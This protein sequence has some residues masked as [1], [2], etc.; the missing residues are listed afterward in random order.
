MKSILLFLSV[1]SGIILSAQN[2]QMGVP[3]TDENAISTNPTTLVMPFNDFVLM[4]YEHQN[5]MD[6]NSEIWYRDISNFGN[7]M[8][9]FA[10]NGIDFLN[11][12]LLKLSQGAND[13]LLFLF[14]TTHI[15][16]NYKV[17]Y[18][19]FD[20]NLNFFQPQMLIS[21][22]NNPRF[23]LD[24]YG[25]FTWIN[26]GSILVNKM[27][28]Q[29]HFQFGEIDTIQKFNA[30]ESF[31]K[32]YNNSAEAIYTLKLDDTLHLFYQKKYTSGWIDPLEVDSGNISNLSINS[33]QSPFPISEFNFVYNNNDTLFGFDTYYE[34]RFPIYCNYGN[35]I[36]ST[37]MLPTTFSYYIPCDTYYWPTVFA[38]I[39][40]NGE[41]QDV[42]LFDSDFWVIWEP[43]FVS[44][45]IY[46]NRNVN[47]YTGLEGGSSYPFWT[48]VFVI[49]ETNMDDKTVLFQTD[50]LWYWCSSVE[51]NK[52]QALD[53]T[54]S[55][56]PAIDC[57]SIKFKTNQLLPI[58]LEIWSMNNQLIRN[59]E[60]NQNSVGENLFEWNLDKKISP[61]IYIIRLVQGESAAIKKIILR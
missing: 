34:E 27:F 52:N 51:E 44:N 35:I 22:D 20:Q 3:I 7:E 32:G 40:D 54:V 48:E 26:N 41:K 57:I 60:F 46:E 36:D 13:F 14:Y 4:V 29:E 56:N 61:G 58:E 55:P 11:P 1:C 2:I 31:V 23:F 42:L 10:E 5:S 9:L 43:Q 33:M 28:Y 53:L 17:W 25:F 37:L 21:Q 16:N 19:Q 30:S 39:A 59:I 12:Q 8:V 18:V 45:D 38:C 49:W 24:Y 15:E 6:N 50:F 47:F